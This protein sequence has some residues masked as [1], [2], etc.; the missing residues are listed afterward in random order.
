[1]QLVMEDVV[2]QIQIWSKKIETYG[3][4]LYQAEEY[5]EVCENVRKRV[6][7]PILSNYQKE[8]IFQHEELFEVFEEQSNF[9]NKFTKKIMEIQKTNEILRK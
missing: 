7:K 6:L 3:Y 2:N 1:M 8:G 4:R 9:N 5:R